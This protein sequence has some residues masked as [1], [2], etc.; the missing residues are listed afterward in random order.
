[1]IEDEVN[2]VVEASE[3]TDMSEV[4]ALIEIGETEEIEGTEGIDIVNAHALQNIDHLGPLGAT[5]MMKADPKGTGSV[6]PIVTA[7]IWI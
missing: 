3:A 6:R 7:D 2:V 4:V 5:I 1:M